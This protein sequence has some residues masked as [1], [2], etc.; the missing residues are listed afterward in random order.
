M[1]EMQSE[2]I[3]P[4]EY[5]RY[6]LVRLTSEMIIPESVWLASYPQYPHIHAES[7]GVFPFLAIQTMTRFEIQMDQ[8]EIDWQN[9]A[10]VKVEK[11]LNRHKS[12]SEKHSIEFKRL[13]LFRF[14][15]AMI[16]KDL[17]DMIWVDE[18]YFDRGVLTLDE[19]YKRAAVFIE[20]LDNTKAGSDIPF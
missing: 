17:D 4:T 16:N 11:L 12:L 6:H 1:L 14:R 5:E 10:A 15:I 9:K 7:R 8:W 13:E 19:I 18:V 20:D 2:Y 3:R